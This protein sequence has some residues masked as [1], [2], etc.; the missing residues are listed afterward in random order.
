MPQFNG[1]FKILTVNKTASSVKL[2]LPPHSKVHPIFHTS[3]ILPYKEN[4]AQ[5]FSEQEFAKPK[6]II[7]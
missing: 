2:N 5:M 7:N 1:L 3:L 4:D 6:L